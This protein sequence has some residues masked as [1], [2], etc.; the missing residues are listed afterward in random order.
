MGG[1]ILMNVPLFF[2]VSGFLAYKENM[3]LNLLLLK[4]IRYLLLPYICAIVF[5]MLYT[6]TSFNEIMSAIDK[7]GFWFLQALFL[8]FII[9]AVTYKSLNK[10]KY[11]LPIMLAIE[12]G[13]LAAS[14]FVPE[15]IDNY[16]GFSSLSRYFPCFIIG[17][18]IRKYR[19]WDKGLGI[20]KG[21]VCLILA[22]IPFICDIPSNN[23]SFIMSI[24]S[25]CAGSILIFYFIRSEVLTIPDWIV[26]MLTTFGRYTISIYIIHFYF[27]YHIPEIT[28][29]SSTI[30]LI[31]TLL[32]AIVIS[33]ICILISKFLTEFTPIKY[34]LPVSA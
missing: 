33:Y 17:V 8:I 14:K 15:I 22:I 29:I 13:L 1:V 7:H 5:S 11:S 4:K 2:V 30:M 16:I 3:T 12:T 34:I 31:P 21:T 10:L 23:L 18:F 20:A 28:D 26:K 9:Y 19:L 25:Y 24:L 6:H 27:V 32:L